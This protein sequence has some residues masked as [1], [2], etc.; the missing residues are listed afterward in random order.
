[1]FLEVYTEVRGMKSN[2]KNMKEQ[3]DKIDYDTVHTSMFSVKK[4][5]VGWIAYWAFSMAEILFPEI[6]Y[7]IEEIKVIVYLTIRYRNINF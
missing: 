2:L 5:R 6:S 4:L 1:M 7:T 3:D